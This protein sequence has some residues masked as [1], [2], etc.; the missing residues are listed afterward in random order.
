MDSRMHNAK[1][2]H[3]AADH[4]GLVAKKPRVD[5]GHHHKDKHKHSKPKKEASAL[6]KVPQRKPMISESDSEGD[7]PLAVRKPQLQNSKLSTT[8]P[9]EVKVQAK[10]HVSSTKSKRVKTEPLPTSSSSSNS[11]SE[12][13]ALRKA[14][15]AKLSDPLTVK[16]EA[17]PTLLE[18]TP[19]VKSDAPPPEAPSKAGKKRRKS[20][21][22]SDNDND[23]DFKPKRAKKSG[24]T[25]KKPTTPTAARK[26]P[27]PKAATPAKRSGST[28]T[29][30]AAASPD[31]RSRGRGGGAGGSPAKAGGGGGGRRKKKEEE[32][33]V[34]KWWEES[35]HPQGVKWVTLEHK[36]PY[37]A[38]PYERLPDDVRFVYDGHEMEL[39]QNAEEAA[40]FFAKMLDHDYTSKDVFC[41]NFFQDWR[42]EM[43]AKEAEMIKK[44][45]LCDF[46]QL[47]A[48]YQARAEERK[49]MS[50]EDKAKVKAENEAILAEYGWCLI[51]GHKERIGNFKTEPP[52]LFRGRG[53]HPKQ[54]RIKKR[55][56]AEDVTIN[57]GKKVEVP[58]PPP[59]HRWK[60]VQH[61]NKVTWLASWT[62]NIQGA[63]KYIMLN[64]TSRLKG[65][66]DWAKYEVARKL[67]DCVED[68]RK[69][70]TVDMRHKEM[71][72]RQRSVAVYFIDKL[73][74]RAG[75]EK[76]ADESADT[77]GC[78]SLRV[79]HLTLHEELDG[80]PC[81]VEFDFLGKDSIR[82]YNK[83][84]VDRQVFKNLHHFTE[85]KEGSDD[86]FDRLTT[87]MLNKHLSELMP[88]LTAKVFRTYN[89]SKTLQD[90]LEELT[91]PDN[92]LPN[93]ILSYNRA[94]RAVAILCNHQ[95]APPKT[96]DQQMSNLQ[97]KVQAKE[98]AIVDAQVEL[99]ALQKEARS[100]KDPKVVKKLDSKRKA[101]GRL[102]DQ[103]VK[104]EVQ[105]TDK[106]EN[107]E[108]ALGTSKLNYLDPRISVSWCKKQEVPVEKVYN[109]SQR[110][111]FAWA[112]D[113][114]GEDF[115]F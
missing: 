43:T 21:T 114:A 47:H 57:I 16:M 50:K 3:P 115:V 109:K 68:I 53:D 92:S 22:E 59:E 5:K 98:E 14:E 80:K 76:D 51:D 101:L 55:I 85:S 49:A 74:L 67:K 112:I 88:G 72:I 10:V 27:P 79:E 84:P 33:E 108:I 52:G 4:T 82:Y 69:Q 89:A 38:P 37:F 110:D 8:P 75:N 86:L 83:V 6:V 34:W 77:V 70:Y 19:T 106:Q 91:N 18:T 30:A 39:S 60:L 66:K 103:L 62:E 28:A 11:T 87:T 42:K 25:R 97:S 54:G 15:L 45:T 36:G 100:T 40:G 73:A 41:D 99:K 20:H 23:D 63:I 78:C 65:E 24:S 104:L 44:F 9:G 93:K 17:T 12:E 64:P 111:K 46:S 102:E 107:K 94:N 71:K 13:L 90:Q 48:Y 56:E 1:H 35:P 113:M 29:A 95:R 26:P 7:V 61:D 58:S 81:V 32:K 96:F 2:P 105:A 31:K